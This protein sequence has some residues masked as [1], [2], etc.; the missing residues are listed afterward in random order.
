M[1][2]S[3]FLPSPHTWRPR[4]A[5]QNRWKLLESQP[6]RINFFGRWS[7]ADSQL[8][9]DTKQSQYTTLLNLNHLGESTE[10][11]AATNLYS[12]LELAM[13]SSSSARGL[14]LRTQSSTWPGCFLPNLLSILIVAWAG[15]NNGTLAWNASWSYLF[16]T[17]PI[18]SLLV[19]IEL[20]T[21]LCRAT[22]T[23]HGA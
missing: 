10:N 19:V 12:T 23:M 20:V 11:W 18:P 7:E 9:N 3:G 5:I 14:T 13:M 8:V 22:R 15:L 2:W 6:G 16:G 1:I 17:T 4:K 21:F